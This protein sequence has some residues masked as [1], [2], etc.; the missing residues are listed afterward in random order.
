MSFKIYSNDSIGSV[1]WQRL[2]DILELSGLNKRDLQSLQRGFEHS[3]FRYLG[4]CDGK[5]IATARA[6]S[7]LTSAS[8]LSDVAIHPDYQG[9]G[10][11]KLLMQRIMQD[12]AP[13]GKVIIYAVPDKIEFY[14]RF[15]FHPLLTAMTYAEGDALTRLS[16]NGYIPPLA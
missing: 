8:Y 6:I 15:S 16:S 14:K 4:Y 7:D 10:F 1:D 13:F 2:A 3:Q 9:R 5:L 11:G 12:L